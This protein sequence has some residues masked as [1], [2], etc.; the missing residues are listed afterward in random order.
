M[1]FQHNHVTIRLPSDKV[2]EWEMPKRMKFENQFIATILIVNVFL[3]FLIC[4]LASLLPSLFVNS[5]RLPLL[6]VC[7]CKVRQN[8]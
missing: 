8:F 1:Y 3:E 7:I 4:L 6:E 5:Q 2:H